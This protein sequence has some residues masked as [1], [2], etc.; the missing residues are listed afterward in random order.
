MTGTTKRSLPVPLDQ[1]TDSIFFFFLTAIF[2][3]SKKKV[4]LNQSFSKPD[5]I[6]S[7]ACL[8]VKHFVNVWENSG[9]GSFPWF[10]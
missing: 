4:F 7:M 5:L 3:L 9:D 10:R 2:F 8:G 1:K 6:N